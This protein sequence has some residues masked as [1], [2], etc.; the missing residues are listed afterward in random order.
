MLLSL[1]SCVISRLCGHLYLVA[2]ATIIR[3][4]TPHIIECTSIIFLS[5]IGYVKWLGH[6]VAEGPGIRQT[7]HC[8]CYYTL[9]M[10]AK[11]V[12]ARV[13]CKF[14]KIWCLGL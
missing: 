11:L 12:R 7:H 10:Y 2:C 9:V 13:Y 4:H 5:Q 6:E 14:L 1:R 8:I 3:L